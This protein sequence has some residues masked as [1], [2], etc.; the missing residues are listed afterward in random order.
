MDFFNLLI[1]KKVLLIISLIINGLLLSIVGFL[2]WNLYTYECVMPEYNDNLLSQE[3]VVEI[4][5]KIYVDVKGEVKKPG[6][7][8]I[9]KESIINDV[10]TLAGGF[11]KKAFSD[12]INL[13]K[14]VSNELVIY[15]Y[16]ETEYKKLNESEKEVIIKECI[17]PEYDIT[18]CITNGSSEIVVE[19][20][21][22]SNDNNISIDDSNKIDNNQN[23]TNKDEIKNEL[24]LININTAT[25]EELMTLSG[26][27][28]SKATAII[29]Y[30]NNTK[31]N[32]IEDIKN[33]SGIGD[34]AFEKIKDYITV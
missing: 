29:E 30:R 31:F 5:E 34:S 21:N 17:C 2:L 25:K 1:E 24:K 12:N 8:E 6:V 16:S 22:A 19:D 15:V 4:D 23:E 10:I 27:G 28:E 13:S 18:D 9:N 3:E 26:I 14:K 20:S 11:T 32:S 7:Y 33:V